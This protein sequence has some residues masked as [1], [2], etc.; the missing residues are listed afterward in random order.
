[1]SGN[2][3]ECSI[4]SHCTVGDSSKL[5]SKL[6]LVTDKLSLYYSYSVIAIV[7][8]TTGVDAWIHRSS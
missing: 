3:A 7:V 1:M 6:K 5:F 4:Q 8:E 2:F